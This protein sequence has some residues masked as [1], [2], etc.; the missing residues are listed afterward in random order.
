MRGRNPA[1]K[2]GKDT[3]SRIKVRDDRGGKGGED[4]REKLEWIKKCSLLIDKLTRA[5]DYHQMKLPADSFIAGDKLTRYLLVSQAHGDKSAYLAQVGYT[6]RNA[7]D[8]LQDLRLQILSLDAQ[9]LES[10]K[11]GQYYEIRG[12]LTG[13]NGGTLAVRTIWITE[14]LSGITKFVTLIPDKGKT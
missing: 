14:H 2:K 6:L 11:F 4:S 7:D 3:G 13:P 10:N 12:T 8:L 1:R 5:R 9:L